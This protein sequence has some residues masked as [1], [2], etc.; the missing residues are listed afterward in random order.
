MGGYNTAGEHG[1]SKNGSFRSTH[2]TVGIHFSNA[3][4]PADVSDT[5]EDVRPQRPSV[6]LGYP[7]N[8]YMVK[9]KLKMETVE[10]IGRNYR[11][12]NGCHHWRSQRLIDTSPSTLG[13]TSYCASSAGSSCQC[14]ARPRGLTDS[15]RIFTRVVKEVTG[16]GQMTVDRRNLCL[17]EK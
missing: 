7:G 4:C 5:H 2:D 6:S 12:G 1:K 13:V 17:G 10:S 3:I 9:Q 14:K 11:W 16:L 8:N 15:A